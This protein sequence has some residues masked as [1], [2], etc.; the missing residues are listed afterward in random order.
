MEIIL[1]VD[2]NNLYKIINMVDSQRRNPTENTIESILDDTAS[3]L[4]TYGI[5][6]FR[7]S[8]KGDIVLSK[9][10]SIYFT[11]LKNIECSIPVFK[12]DSKITLVDFKRVVEPEMLSEIFI[13]LLSSNIQIKNLN[14]ES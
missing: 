4:V 3:E 2:K 12:D 11:D 1:N 10:G 6:H 8:F 5:E 7:L 14:N 13:T 9:S